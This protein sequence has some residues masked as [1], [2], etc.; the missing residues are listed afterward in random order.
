ML[1]MDAPAS[2]SLA[3]SHV[4]GS[5]SHDVSDSV[6]AVASGVSHKELVQTNG[7]VEPRHVVDEDD[8]PPAY[9]S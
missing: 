3:F 8:A 9:A 7:D 4:Q 6:E 1:D 5:A 2:P